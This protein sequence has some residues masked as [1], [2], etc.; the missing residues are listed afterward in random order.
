MFTALFIGS[1]VLGLVIATYGLF[2]TRDHNNVRK[3]R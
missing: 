2:G 3:R 1:A